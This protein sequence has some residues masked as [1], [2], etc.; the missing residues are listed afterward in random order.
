MFDGFEVADEPDLAVGDHV[1]EFSHRL[2]VGELPMV[3]DVRDAEVEGVRHPEVVPQILR[4]TQLHLALSKPLLRNLLHKVTF[5]IEKQMQNFLR[6]IYPGLK[7]I[8]ITLLKIIYI[9]NEPD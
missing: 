2:Q 9:V 6:D 8:E 7:H 3:E 5:A 4:Q 1:S